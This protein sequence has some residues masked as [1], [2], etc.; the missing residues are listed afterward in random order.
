MTENKKE[1]ISIII[2]VFNEEGSIGKVLED[3]PKDLTNLI[4]VVDNGSTDQSIEVASRKGA[5]VLSQTERG[6]GAACLKGIEYLKNNNPPDILV[7]L[8]GDYSD[9]PEDMRKLI[10]KVNSGYDFVLGSRVMGVQTNQAKLS[11]HSILGNRLAAYFLKILF[12]GN[13]TD[14]G[15]FRAI[16]FNKL[17]ILDMQDRNFGWT[18][19]MQI[20]AVSKG[21]KICEI[22]VQY[23]ARFAGES[24]VT[25]TFKGSVKAFVKITYIVILYFLRIRR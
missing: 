24:K 3:I 18:M 1:K 20:K 25:G 12:R 9:F 6:Y 5:F 21:L 22:P 15:P 4:I 23:R 17:L 7:F 8:D 13:F 14:L 2:P 10:E 16:K 11:S 19:E